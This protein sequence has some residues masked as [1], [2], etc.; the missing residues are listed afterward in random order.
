[1]PDDRVVRVAEDLVGLLGDHRLLP[2]RLLGLLALLQLLDR[3]I[4]HLGL[5]HQVLLDDLLDLSHRQRGTVGSGTTEGTSSST[6]Q[7][8]GRDKKVLG[9]T[10]RLRLARL[11]PA[12]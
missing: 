8:H 5:A 9:I 6:R 1:M 7:R 12:A 4:D 3:L 2:R 11:T 10:G